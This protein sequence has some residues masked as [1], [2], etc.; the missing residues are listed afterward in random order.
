MHQDP[1]VTEID[2]SSILSIQS[3]PAREPA[4]V[5]AAR[6]QI[7]LSLVVHLEEA[8]FNERNDRDVE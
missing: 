1:A 7:C 8:F 6:N 4:S 5:I 2:I 3:E